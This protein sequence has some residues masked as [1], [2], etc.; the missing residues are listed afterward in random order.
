MYQDL[1]DS[2]DEGG[3]MRQGEKRRDQGRRMFGRMIGADSPPN[4][5]SDGAKTEGELYRQLSKHLIG[6]DG[7]GLGNELSAP[8]EVPQFPIEQ[9]QSKLNRVKD[10]PRAAG[11]LQLPAQSS[12]GSAH[13]D[14]D[15]VDF[16]EFL[17]DFQRV[18]I[19]GEDNTGGSC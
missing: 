1:Q 3:D 10:G 16:S 11:G 13:G 18:N 12:G 2:D 6:S 15:E 8:Y 5:R 7:Q 14:E 19:S 4:E 9:I 17:P